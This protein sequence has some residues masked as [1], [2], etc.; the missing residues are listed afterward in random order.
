M[1]IPIEIMSKMAGTKRPRE[2]VDTQASKKV[3]SSKEGPKKPKFESENAAG[4]E[5]DF[6]AF[7]EGLEEPVSEGKAAFTK[8]PKVDYGSHKANG[9][10]NQD[11]FLSGSTSREAHA[12]QRALAQDRKT[13]WIQSLAGRMGRIRLLCSR[14]WKP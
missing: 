1:G 13:R 4:Q 10:N 6:V 12:K 11:S 7:D 9:S 3:K 14:C 5:E 2:N 8:K